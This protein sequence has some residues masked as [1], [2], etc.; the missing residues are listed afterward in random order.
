VAHLLN[1]QVGARPNSLWPCSAAWCRVLLLARKEWK[2]LIN[3]CWRILTDSVNP[4]DSHPLLLRYTAAYRPFTC[5]A[6][7]CLKSK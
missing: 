7:F 5:V 3:D 4:S 2:C 6:T 1:W